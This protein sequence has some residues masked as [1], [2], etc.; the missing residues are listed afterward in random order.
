[1][2]LHGV[3]KLIYCKD[4]G[5]AYAILNNEPDWVRRFHCKECDKTINAYS[6]PCENCYHDEKTHYG[7][8]CEILGCNCE[9]YAQ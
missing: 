3:S 4:C 9:R 6:H 2:F 7:I 8:Q 5:S 1:M